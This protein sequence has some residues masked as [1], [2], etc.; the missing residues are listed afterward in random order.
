VHV[1]KIATHNAERFGRTLL[2]DFGWTFV[3]GECNGNR[4]PQYSDN[5]AVILHVTACG[6]RVSGNNV[7][8]YSI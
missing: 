1:R 3:T 7:I 6:L 8:C 4:K 5:M 2:T